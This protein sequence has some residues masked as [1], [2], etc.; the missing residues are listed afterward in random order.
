MSASTYAELLAHVGHE[1]EVVAYGSATDPNNVAV[2]CV[3]CSTVLL[4]FDAPGV[5][6]PA[7]ELELAAAR[8]A[9]PAT[10]AALSEEASALS[11]PSELLTGAE[12]EVVELLG[13]AASSFAVN[14]V[15][16]NPAT[17]AADIDEFCSRIHDLQARV[18]AQAAARAYP[19]RYRRS[20]TVLTPKEKPDA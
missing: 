18:M 4:D 20:G 9:H 13:Q 14:V 17:R 11:A 3:T 16:F 8:L 7:D 12:H 1:V 15:D 6:T 10:P 2:E 5:P 19:D